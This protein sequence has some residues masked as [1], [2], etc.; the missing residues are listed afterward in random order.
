MQNYNFVIF[1]KHF[2]YYRIAYS[3][4]IK[5]SD[6]KYID[7]IK[8][9]RSKTIN[10]ILRTPIKNLIPAGYFKAIFPTTKPLCFIF[11]ARWMQYLSMQDYIL[12]LR[13]HF[14]DAKFVCFYQDLVD[15]HPRAEPDK[16]RQLFDLM[17][18]YD[19]G[20]VE[21]YGLTYHSTVFSNYPVEIDSNI[22]ASDIYFVGVAK[23]RL[24]MILDNFYKFKSKGINCD[25]YLSEVPSRN[26]VKEKGLTYID[27][28]SYSENLKHVVRSKCL[29]EII[30]SNAKGAT[31]RTWEAIMYDKKLL[32]NNYSVVDDFYYNDSY[33]SLLGENEID[34]ELLKQDNHFI[35]P[36]KN[37]IG[38]NSLLEFISSSF[39]EERIYIQNN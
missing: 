15:K 8:I 25:F 4:I 29:L 12:Y 38:P 16:L 19:K 17:L 13:K 11:G 34:A 10:A 7:K 23:D 3:D 36:Y 5:R 9:H 2:D 21:K 6:V 28:M 22:P 24:N 33:I 27:R 30:Q 31:V 26:Q 14:P 35:N 37:E 18:S 20:D 39:T 32:T 1:Q